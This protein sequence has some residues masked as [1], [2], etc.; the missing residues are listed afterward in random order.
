MA[1][2]LASIFYSATAIRLKTFV[3]LITGYAIVMF[4]LQNLFLFVSLAGWNGLPWA[5]GES[6]LFK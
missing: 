3:S 1:E 4:I 2:M 6:D 5:A